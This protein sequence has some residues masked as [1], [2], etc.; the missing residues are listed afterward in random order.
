MLQ[1]Y[2]FRYIAAE[3]GRLGMAVH[4]H[5][6]AG[7]GGYFDVSGANPLNLEGVL[8]DPALR[9]TKFVMVHGGWPFTREI[10][11]LL[12]KPNAYLDFSAQ[13]LLLSPA[14]LAGTLREWL[15]HVPEKVMFATDAYP[16]SN[17]MG[18]E[19]GGWIAAHNGREALGRALTGD[20]ARR[21]DHAHACRGTGAH[22][23]ARQRARTV[24]VLSPVA[25]SLGTA[26]QPTKYRG[27]PVFS[28]V[29]GQ[30][31][32]NWGLLGG[33]WGGVC[34]L[35]ER[36]QFRACRSTQAVDVAIEG[37]VRVG[38]G[39]AAG[40]AEFG[41]GAVPGA[42]EGGDLALHA[43][44]EFGSGGVGEKGGG[45]GGAGGF[46][47]EG[48]VEVGLDALEAEF[49]P[50]GAEHGVD[51]EGLGGGLGT[52]V[53]MVGGDEGFVVGGV[54][55]WDDDGGGVDA[56]FQGIE[57]GGGLALGGAGSGGLLRVGAIGVDL[58]GGCHD[59]DLARRLR[60]F[61]GGLG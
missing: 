41:V 7:A 30:S 36:S 19:E 34:G 1:D 52:E 49:L 17:E 54:F 61:W 48:A 32:L 20:A 21:R 14:T 42:F 25:L 56:V 39:L 37:V 10:T 28:S 22:G 59:S 58:C 55:A 46:G 47:E 57:A 31:L 40:A 11:P 45:E 50:V 13:S 35:G 5:T 44:E 24:R 16:Y 9:K 2:L 23:A 8:N 15:E 60:E 29:G 3:C 38:F 43:G 18:W 12:E 6:A 51:V 26:F 27:R 33:G 4:L 53:A